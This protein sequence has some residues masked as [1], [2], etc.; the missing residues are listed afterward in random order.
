VFKESVM[1][2]NQ[3]EPVS[4]RVVLPISPGPRS[5]QGLKQVVLKI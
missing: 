5:I 3:A 4:E 2:S 1:P